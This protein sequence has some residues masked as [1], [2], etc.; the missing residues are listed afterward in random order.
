MIWE[1]YTKGWKNIFNFTGRA[2]RAEYWIFNILN[3]IFIT[4][5]LTIIFSAFAVSFD[6][7]EEALGKVGMLFIFVIFPYLFAVFSQTVRRIRDIGVSGWWTVLYLPVNAILWG[8][9]AIIIGLIPSSKY[10]QTEEKSNAESDKNSSQN[11]KMP[12][13]KPFEYRNESKQT[14]QQSTHDAPRPLKRLE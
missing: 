9:P 14:A 2:T 12:D 6:K 4:L 8:I 1:N 11:D 3:W 10:S 13:L 7:P 5:L